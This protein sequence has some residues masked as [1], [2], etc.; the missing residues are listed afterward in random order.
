MSDL[1]TELRTAVKNGFLNL[2]LHRTWD[3]KMWLCDY[4]TTESTNYQSVGDVNP[5]EAVRKAL[6]GGT[7]DAKEVARK[8][9][10]R[11]VEDLA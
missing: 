4:R 3:G 6:R 1:E 11:I 5:V 7:R 8:R 2:S 10:Q 9:P